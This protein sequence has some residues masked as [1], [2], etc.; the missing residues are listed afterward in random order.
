LLAA[1]RKSQHDHYRPQ[2]L[3]WPTALLYALRRPAGYVYLLLASAW[4]GLFYLYAFP[5]GETFRLWPGAVLE[6]LS[7]AILVAAVA[8][9]PWKAADSGDAEGLPSAN[10]GILV[11]QS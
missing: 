1:T 2:Y 10:P 7:I 4:L 6:V 5:S 8:S 3:L 9:M 11:S